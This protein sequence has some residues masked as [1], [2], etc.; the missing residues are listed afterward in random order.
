MTWMPSPTVCPRAPGYAPGCAPGHNRRTRHPAAFSLIEIMVVV[1]IVV[2]IVGLGM[3]VMNG[4]QNNARISA[5]RLTLKA[6]QNIANEYKIQTGYVINHDAYTPTDNTAK[7]DWTQPKTYTTTYYTRTPPDPKAWPL[8]ADVIG[9][10]R[11]W[12]PNST[13]VGAPTTPISNWGPPTPNPYKT[14]ER[15]V[16]AAWQNPRTADML[17]A[18]GPSILIE[19]HPIPVD[20]SHYTNPLGHDAG[21]M[22]IVDAWG[23]PLEYRDHSDGSQLPV[24]NTPFFASAGRDAKF[25]FLD[26]S[27]LPGGAGGGFSPSDFNRDNLYSFEVK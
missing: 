3:A 6:S 18:L 24:Y 25:G 10:T 26:S 2:L 23:K 19:H 4:V 9:D 12:L 17:L 20:E 11:M 1:T 5:T 22:N 13:G 7:I 21:F 14:I 16:W 8:T 15:F 27:D